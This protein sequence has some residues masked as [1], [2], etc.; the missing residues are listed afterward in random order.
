M[1]LCL[2]LS[3]NTIAVTG[4]DRQWEMAQKIQELMQSGRTEEAMRLYEEMMRES[5]SGKIQVS[6]RIVDD[7]GKPLDD[8]IME[9]TRLEYDD[10]QSTD[11]KEIKKTRTVNGRFDYACDNCSGVRLQFAKDG[12]YRD[13]LE[14]VTYGD[15]TPN[16][17]VINKN[18]IVKLAKMG[19]RVVLHRYSGMLKVTK[20]SSDILPFSFGQTTRAEPLERL[21]VASKRYR[22][23]GEVRYLELKV[24][25]DANGE[26]VLQ[27]IAWPGT[28][29]KIERPVDAMLDFTAAD[30]GVIGYE[31]V[32]HFVRKIGLEMRRAP[33]TGYQA[34]LALD[35]E[36]D[37]DQYF[38][39]RIGDH[40][41]RGRITPV[42][43]NSNSQGRYASANIAIRLNPTPG[44]TNLEY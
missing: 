11:L 31:P 18:L 27:E 28:R 1:L 16:R 23:E 26:I 20:N 30:G 8:V 36:T 2:T 22:H 32:S 7:K 39:C 17:E 29:S 15:D 13:T 41:G 14:F 25:R 44:D 5:F 4:P 9:I 6:G 19:Q 10:L 37:N 35:P 34:T 43:I 38:Y 12:Y 24:R 42:M 33:E 40:Y 3:Q 21:D